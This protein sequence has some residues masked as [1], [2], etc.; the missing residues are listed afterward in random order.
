MKLSE[1]EIKTL[2]RLKKRQQFLRR[3]RSP[4]AVFHGLCIVA[5]LVLLVVVSRFP[6]GDPTAKLIVV[7]YLL[8]PI[9]IF[10]ALHSLFLGVLIRDWHGDPSA[11]LLLKVIDE[12]Q[13]SD[14]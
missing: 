9:F 8:P 5:W 6:S 4:L 13:H 3:W 10:L 11:D 2:T 7:S 14:D 12:L 1:A